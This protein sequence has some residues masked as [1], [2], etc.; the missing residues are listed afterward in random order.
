MLSSLLRPKTNR[1]RIEEGSLFSVPYAER[2]H[3]TADFTSH[4]GEDENTEEDELDD[5]DDYEEDQQEE[6]YIEEEDGEPDSPLLPIFSAVH[7]GVS[8]QQQQTFC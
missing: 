1:Q 6:A 3:A 5:G 2:V 4:D 8:I 7:L